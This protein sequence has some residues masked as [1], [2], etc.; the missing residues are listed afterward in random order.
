MRIVVHPSRQHRG[1]QAPLLVV[2]AHDATSTTS[3]LSCEHG[4]RRVARVV[5]RQV[6][7]CAVE[8]AESSRP[9]HVGLGDFTR[10]RA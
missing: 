10:D 2:L 6:A 7:P 3:H 8:L 4:R 5:R 1:P 9:T